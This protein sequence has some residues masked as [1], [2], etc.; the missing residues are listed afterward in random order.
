MAA[1]SHDV[2]R[3]AG[4]SQSTV[5]RA[6]RGE[7]G[8]ALETRQRVEE[9][10]GSLGYVASQLGRSLATRRTRRI[11][12]V[13][14]ELTNPFYPHL[15]E[16]LHNHFEQ[17][18][19]RSVLYA[20]REDNRIEFAE[21][22]DG[23]L[24]G[25]VLTTTLLDSAL[26]RALLQR[27]MPFV[28][29]NRESGEGGADTVVMDNARGAELVAELL[30]GLGHRRIGAVFGPQTTSTG[31]QR[32]HGFRRRLASDGVELLPNATAHGPF[33]FAQGETGLRALLEADPAPTAVFCA[34]DV[35]AL[36]ALNEATRLGVRVPEDLTVVGFDDISMSSMA[37]FN[38]TTVHTDL[39]QLVADAA[40]LLL[41][42]IDKRGRAVRRIV[43]QPELVL[44]GTHGGPG[45]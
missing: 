33:A 42:R 10:A 20:E 34:N 30:L 28:F 12:I 9:A 7:P 40:D 31:V 24:D 6:L 35:L 39:D 43:Q 22:V 11:G 16:P 18:G 32:E 26:P 44:R 5:S 21:L 23:S 15:V 36:G 41:K 2:A 13:A 1:T 45:S 25:I 37:R 14:A 17:F 4:V 19:Y 8:I 29:L 38:L 27:G 3:L